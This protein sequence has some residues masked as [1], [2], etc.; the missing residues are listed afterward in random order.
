MNNT[1]N[2]AIDVAYQ[3]RELMAAHGLQGWVFQWDRAKRR[4]GRC[5]YATRVISL[6]IYYVQN[7]LDKPDDILDTI[8]HEIAHALAGS[9]NGHNHVW[10]SWCRRIGARP[11]RCYDS[12][13]VEMPRGKYTAKCCKCEREYHYHRKPRYKFEAYRCRPCGRLGILK[14]T[15]AAG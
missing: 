2:S 10:R 8:L 13:K 5:C 7:N 14:W 6:S 3:A 9:G 11:V 12:S 15:L 1:L 4:A